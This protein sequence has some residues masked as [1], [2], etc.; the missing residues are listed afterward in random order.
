[1]KKGLYTLSIITFLVFAINI[2]AYSQDW[3]YMG[4][5]K[6]DNETIFYVFSMKKD[7]GNGGIIKLIQKHIFG[8][9]QVLEDGREYDSVLIDRTLNCS[10]KSISIDKIVLSNGIGNKVDTYADKSGKG[11][12]LISDDNK[13]DLNLYEQYCI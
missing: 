5:S 6:L 10:T 11:L 12:Q 1:M 3:N 2:N 9:S 13:I 4:F 8:S 7:T